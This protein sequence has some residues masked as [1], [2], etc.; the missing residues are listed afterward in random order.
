MT[1]S[2][3]RFV[4]RDSEYSLRI[5]GR[6]VHL[7]ARLMENGADFAVLAGQATRVEVCFL[8]LTSPYVSERRFRLHR[9]TYGIWSGHVPGI[10][11]GQAYGYR[12]WGKWKPNL[13]QKHNPAKLLLDPYARGIIQAP[14]LDPALFSHEVNDDLHPIDGMVA[15][16]R[17]SAPVAAIGMVMNE[18]ESVTDRPNTP[19]DQTVIYEAHVVGLTK[20]LEGIPQE[21]RGTY[22]GVAHPV[23]INYLRSLGVTAIELL[24]IHAKM[25][26][27]FLTERGLTNYWGYSTLSYF[28]P[29]PSYATKG[30]QAL[31]PDGV[32]AEVRGMVSLLHKAGIEVIL[33]VVYN[34]TCEAGAD[35]PT[36][37]WRGLDN[38]TYYRHDSARPGVLKDTTGTGNSLDFRRTHVVGMT[39]D[40]LRYWVE[41][42]GID[43]FR[44]DLAVTG[45][46][47]GD[48]FLYN[49]PLYVAM[50]TDPILSQVKLINE[51]WDLGYDGWRTGQFPP[52]TADWNDRFRDTMRRYWVTEPAAIAG[53]GYGSDAR[54]FAT[55][56]SGSADLFSHGRIPGGRG[57]YASVNFITAHDG[58][59]MYD[60]VSYNAK[61]NEANG[62]D[63]RDGTND[64]HSWN[65]GAEGPASAEIEAAR[66]KT[67]RNLMAM[68]AFSAGTPMLR[69]GDERLDSQGGNNNAYC[70]DNEISWID[71]APSEEKNNMV[72]TVSYLLS[73]RRDHSVLRPLKFFTGA[74]TAGDSLPDVVWYD[75]HGDELTDHK[76]YNREVRTL[77]MLRSGGGKDADALLVLNGNPESK[78]VVLPT[79]RGTDYT[80]VW[81]STWARPRER[82]VALKPGDETLVAPTSIQLYLA[83]PA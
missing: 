49:H 28:S 8:D 51:P 56:I 3:W 43:G 74:Q 25:S 55:R 27:P 68:L 50:A 30:N 54:D 26:E 21:L 14:T 76:W 44:F 10:R 35:G 82:G 66:R 52:P 4:A 45:A 13:G 41:K 78:Q 80:L 59:S 1:I 72:E 12:V 20:Q 60:L 47:H 77:L 16:Q 83:N 29:E 17:D 58:F 53:G 65:H 31:G 34:H 75:R 48:A 69:A 22:A 39:L 7:G 19:W 63:G 2:A 79:G 9:G 38:S 24:P 23:T 6:P 36:V 67:I 71:W 81:D 32:L 37:S 40:S 42:V 61:H 57:L 70:Q 11:A 15:D 33:D 5:A 62:E 18:P 73:L 46:R 64:N